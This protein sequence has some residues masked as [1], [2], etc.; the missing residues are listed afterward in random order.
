MTNEGEL[1]GIVAGAYLGGMRSLMIMEN[2]GLRQACEPLA[3]F[4][5]SH[6]VPMVIVVPYRGDLGETN[7]WGHAHAQTM[8]PVARR[9]TR[10]RT[11][12]CAN[13]TALADGSDGALRPRRVQP[14]PGRRS[15]SGASA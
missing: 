5:L 12:T 14:D 11:G 4:T 10:S 15:S 3:R 6:Q 13:S 8:E 7:W 9:A 1:P 2:S